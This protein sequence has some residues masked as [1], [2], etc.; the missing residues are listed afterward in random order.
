MKVT[1]EIIIDKVLKQPTPYVG[2]SFDLLT[3]EIGEIS[4]YNE[5]GK[6][7]SDVLKRCTK[8]YC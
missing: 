2:K 4:S 1:Q 8:L 6:A 5:T 7:L 3:K